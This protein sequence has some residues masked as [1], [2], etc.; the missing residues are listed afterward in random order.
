MPAVPWQMPSPLCKTPLCQTTFPTTAACNGLV[1]TQ[2][3]KTTNKY[4]R[5]AMGMPMPMPMPMQIPIVEPPPI[6]VSSSEAMP[7]QCQ[8]PC[9]HY[10]AKRR[11]LPLQSSPLGHPIQVW[12]TA[13]TTQERRGT[14]AR[15]CLSWEFHLVCWDLS[16]CCHS[17]IG[18]TPTTLL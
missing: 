7:M 17:G 5:F 3:Q 6:L 13:T 10:T 16:A 15:V 1:C 8:C 14:T 4:I 9:Q 11:C 2:E 18:T 12:C